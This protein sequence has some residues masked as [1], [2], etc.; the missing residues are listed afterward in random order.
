MPKK[1]KTK[2]R[3]ITFKLTDRQKKS[4]EAYCR[5]VDTTPVKFIKESIRY[6]LNGNPPDLSKRQKS[7]KSSKQI[8]LEELIKQISEEEQ[9]SYQGRKNDSPKDLFS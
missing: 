6:A 8:D 1:R 7:N 3:K 5:E 2:Y 4:L 9:G